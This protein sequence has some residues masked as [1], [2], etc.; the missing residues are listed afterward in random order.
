MFNQYIKVSV[1]FSIVTIYVSACQKY[2]EIPPPDN[3]LTADEVYSNKGAISAAMTGLYQYSFGLETEYSNQYTL[4]STDLFLALATDDAINNEPNFL[5]FYANTYPTMDTYLQSM[6]SAPYLVIGKVNSFIEGITSSTVISDAAKT[7]YI[8]QAR[9][10]RAYYYFILTNLYGDVPLILTSD[11]QTSSL[12]PRTSRVEVDSAIMTDMLF[13]RDHLTPDEGSDNYSFNQ[14]TAN[15][16]LA[17]MYGYKKNWADE[18]AAA[19]DVINSGRY[20]LAAD[21]SSVFNTA[22]SEAVYQVPSKGTWYQGLVL[23]GFLA[24][25]AIL[26][27]TPDLINSFESGDLR[28]SAWTVLNGT[29]YKYHKYS[30][31]SANP[32]E[33]V[34]VRLADVILL[35]AEARAQQNELNGAIDDLNLI[36]ER[37]G[38]PDLPYTL[39]QDQVIKAMMNERRKEFFGEDITRW[40]DLSRWGIMQSTM[41]AAKPTTWTTKAAL[42]PVMN[43]ELSLNPNLKQTPGY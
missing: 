26:T 1:L 34:L 23:S 40:F 32:Q 13:A 7:D 28:L 16:L 37:A 19:T 8:A 41:Q 25:G 31:P 12:L 29:N 27:M 33:L 4:G 35:R 11:I 21:P 30:Y 38:V 2:V 24:P 18:E 14:N 9:L 22:S 43:L 10:I 5:E 17:R 20:T 15:A 6:W 36:R 39:T 3:K 42:F